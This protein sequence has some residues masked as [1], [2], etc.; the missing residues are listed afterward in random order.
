MLAQSAV[1]LHCGAPCSE[2]KEDKSLDEERYMR[3]PSG[4]KKITCEVT[5]RRLL[6]YWCSSCGCENTVSLSIEGSGSGQYHVLSSGVKKA[7]V[8]HDAETEAMAYLSRRDDELYRRINANY[9]YQDIDFDVV[10]QKCGQ[11]QPWSNVPRKWL[12]SP[13][14]MWWFAMMPPVLACAYICAS[15]PVGERYYALRS[16]AAIT[17]CLMYIVVPLALYGRKRAAGIKRMNSASFA[18]PTYYNENNIGEYLRV[19]EYRQS[20]QG[21]D[22]QAGT[23]ASSRDGGKEYSL[24]KTGVRWN[25]GLAWT[26]SLV[27]AV[28]LSGVSLRINDYVKLNDVDVNPTDEAHSVPSEEVESTTTLLPKESEDVATGETVGDENGSAEAVDS[29]SG[30]LAGRTA[31]MTFVAP[32]GWGQE[33][34]G[35]TNYWSRPG[36]VGQVFIAEDTVGADVKDLSRAGLVYLLEVMSEEALELEDYRVISA[37]DGDLDGFPF[38]TFDATGMYE[39]E[40]YHIAAMLVALPDDVH[41]IMAACP[42][43]AYAIYAGAFDAV[44]ESV[45]ISST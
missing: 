26:L 41:I 23:V 35:T 20:V 1:P 21:L 17:I 33:E 3:I 45:S 42:A 25:A 12:E 31:S 34:V 15:L 18:P 19:L 2:K 7:A 14:C 29:G 10:C 9:D 43:D 36:D 30:Y 44:F 4:F 6:R 38:R 8:Q 32:E 22:W 28:V 40:E 39:G 5:K 13:H 27:L 37:H 24:S 16:V 11:L